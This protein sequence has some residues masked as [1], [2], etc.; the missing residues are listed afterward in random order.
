MK[1]HFTIDYHTHW[2]ERIEVVLRMYL[3]QGKV[4]ECSIPLDTTDGAQWKGDFVYTHP[5]A[6]WFEYLYVVRAGEQTVRRE[7]KHAWRRLRADMTRE[8]FLPDSWQ[9]IPPCDH[10]YSAAF[11][12]QQ[13][14]EP[15][16]GPVHD[17]YYDRSVAFRIHVPQLEEDELPAIIGSIPA[18]GAWQTDKAL[19]LTKRGQNEWGIALSAEGMLFP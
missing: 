12:P 14:H 2:G 10:L 18:I 15:A 3:P 16:E 13:E 1:L 6:L 19:P 7:W 17:S 5:A 4:N 8:Y 9:A 11:C